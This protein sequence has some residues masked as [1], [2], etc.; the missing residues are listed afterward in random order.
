MLADSASVR[1]SVFLY[2]HWLFCGACYPDL[3]QGSRTWFLNHSTLMLMDQKV[4]E[5]LVLSLTKTLVS[6]DVILAAIYM[7]LLELT[8]KPNK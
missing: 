2:D 3:L 1:T 4:L 7:E 8:K 6:S 5:V